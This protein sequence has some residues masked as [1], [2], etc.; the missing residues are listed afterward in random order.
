MPPERL[1]RRS[2]ALSWRC[3][4]PQQ[5]SRSTQYRS[6]EYSLPCW[7][8]NDPGKTRQ[9]NENTSA[10]PSSP[11][12]SSLTTVQISAGSY[13]A[14]RFSYFPPRP[15]WL[16]CRWLPPAHGTWELVATVWR[17]GPSVLVPYSLSWLPYPCARKCHTTCCWERRPPR[18]VW[19]RRRWSGCRS[20]RRF[21]S[22]CCRGWRG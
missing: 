6:R 16:C 12:C 20:L 18:T 10:K 13:C 4:A 1:D 11:D 2:V 22:W 21:L 5:S 7:R 3:P 15:C 8:G 19:R 14:Q 17:W 9:S